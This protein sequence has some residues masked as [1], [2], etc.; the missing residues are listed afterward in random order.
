MGIVTTETLAGRLK[1]TEKA[2]DRCHEPAAI[3]AGRPDRMLCEACA[4][5][6]DAEQAERLAARAALEA[7][8]MAAMAA[9]DAD[10]RVIEPV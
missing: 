1:K 4:E 7:H 9:Q 6:E 5:V 10:R 2:C 8:A 3:L